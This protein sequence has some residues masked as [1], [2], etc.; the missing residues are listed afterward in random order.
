MNQ[1]ITTSTTAGTCQRCGHAVR[2]RVGGVCDAVRCRS[3]GER[4]TVG[5]QAIDSERTRIEV[6]SDED[7]VFGPNYGTQ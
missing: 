2:I 5:S 6:E 1:G 7:A 3:C 4:R